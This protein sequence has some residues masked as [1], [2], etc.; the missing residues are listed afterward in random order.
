MPLFHRVVRAHFHGLWIAAVR[1]LF[2]RHILRNV[3]HH[4][5]GA[6]CAGHMKRFFHGGSQ[7]THIFDQEIVLDDGAGNT[8]GVALLEGI[9]ANRRHRSL[10]AD[11]H[12]RNGVCVSSSDTCY[13]IGQAGAGCHQ[14]HAYFTRCTGKAIGCMHGRLLMAHQHV[15]DSVLFVECVVDVEHCTARVAPQVF[16]TFCLKRLDE[17]FSTHQILRCCL[18][19]S[20]RCTGLLCFGD[21]HD[22]PL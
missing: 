14:R 3:D 9:G 2:K 21:F 17:N 18:C 4:R 11:H 8:H 7:I 5:A 1:R 15:L 16:H 10:A 19:R 22:Q 6:T 13:C 20:S 12:Q